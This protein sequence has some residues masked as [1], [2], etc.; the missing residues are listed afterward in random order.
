MD[1]HIDPDKMK[2]F[3]EALAD[4]IVSSQGLC[5][6]EA[7]KEVAKREAPLLVPPLIREGT[8]KDG[9][10]FVPLNKL[11]QKIPAKNWNDTINSL[12]KQIR[13]CLI[14]EGYL[15]DAK[16]LQEYI[17]RMNGNNIPIPAIDNDNQPEADLDSML[18]KFMSEYAFMN[19]GESPSAIDIAR[20]FYG[21][22]PNAK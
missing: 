22:R 18:T 5:T 4:I 20:H 3:E 14:R 2:K 12:A 10:H 19:S 21:L 15:E 17:S 16:A 7:C 6:Y 9:L 1:K 8:V 11:I 13:D